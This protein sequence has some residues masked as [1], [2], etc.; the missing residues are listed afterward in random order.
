MSPLNSILVRLQS[1]VPRSNAGFVILAY[2]L[3]G[4]E[5]GMVVDLSK[6]AFEEHMSTLR[7]VA[8]PISLS[9]ALA[10]PCPSQNHDRPRVVI[11][12]D[13]AYQNF[14]SDALPIVHKHGIP[15]TLYV[16]V[17]FIDGTSPPPITSTDD[18]PAASWDQISA[19]AVEDSL[20]EVGSHGLT[21]ANLTQLPADDVAHEVAESKIALERRLDRPISSFCYPE[22]FFNRIARKIVAKNFDNAVGAGGGRVRSPSRQRDCLPR[23]PVRSDIPVPVLSLVSARLWLPEVIGSKYRRIRTYFR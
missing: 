5:T 9:Q 6:A 19:V 20:V 4:A 2:H 18:L 3:V 7:R 13:D 15:V 23:V 22:G 16:P 8:E 12:F 21:H 1:L 10:E 11:T 17:G 14:F